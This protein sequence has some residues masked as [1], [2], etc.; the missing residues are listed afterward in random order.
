VPQYPQSSPPWHSDPV[1]NEEP[2]GIDVN[3]MP[4][5]EPPTVIPSVGL[6]DPPDAPSEGNLCSPSTSEPGGSS[7]SSTG[8]GDDAA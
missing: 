8:G 1:P 7:S 6:D 4:P 5:L 2:F 3:A